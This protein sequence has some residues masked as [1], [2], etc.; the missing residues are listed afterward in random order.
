MLF[1]KFQ[2]KIKKFTNFSKFRQVLR[3][4]FFKAEN[5]QEKETKKGGIDPCKEREELREGVL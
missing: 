4:P 2:G 3:I 1:E 5:P